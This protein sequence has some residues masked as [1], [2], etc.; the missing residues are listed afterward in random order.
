MYDK[1]LERIAVNSNGLYNIFMEKIVLKSACQV[2]SAWQQISLPLPQYPTF[3]K[4]RHNITYL[5]TM[6]R[7]V[8]TDTLNN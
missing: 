4:P 7:L 6:V 3:S 1:P 5:K 8:I 2:K